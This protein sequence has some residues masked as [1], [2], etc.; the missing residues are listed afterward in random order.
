M[1][2]LDKVL[3]ITI[4]LACLVMLVRLFIGARRRQR[5]DHTVVT[6]WQTLRK[7][8]VKMVRWRASRKAAAQATEEAIRRARTKSGEWEGN[9]YKPDS[10]K[11]PRK[12]H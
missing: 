8:V 11:R 6:G 2:A 5:L 3:P 7:R 4:A 9:V 10:F 1:V 12:P